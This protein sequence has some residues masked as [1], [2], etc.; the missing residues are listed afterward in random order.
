MD[1]SRCNFI[2]CLLT[3]ASYLEND[4][5]LCGLIRKASYV[6]VGWMYMSVEY[7]WKID[8]KT[9]SILRETCSIAT[10]CTRNPTWPTLGLNP[11]VLGEISV[12]AW[13]MLLG[14]LWR[15][16]EHILV[17]INVE[18]SLCTILGCCIIRRG[19]L[20]TTQRII[21]FPAAERWALQSP[22]RSLVMWT[23]NMQYLLH[24]RTIIARSKLK[25]MVT[26]QGNDYSSIAWKTMIIKLDIDDKIIVKH[27]AKIPEINT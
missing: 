1:K 5:R 7:R 18:G 6:V 21:E 8:T 10:L 19:M 9:W 13:Y 16:G 25:I 12:T 20:K 17:A 22:Y 15:K 23:W 3:M 14:C 2:I 11:S 24:Y 27:L 26:L 4:F